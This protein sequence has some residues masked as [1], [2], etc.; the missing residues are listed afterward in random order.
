MPTAQEQQV[1][2]DLRRGLQSLY[3][4]RLARL[5]LFGSRARG[6]AEP[7]SDYDVL[8]VLRGVVDPNEESR[9]TS[10]FLGDI[11]SA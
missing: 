3:G 11:Q 5:I 9:R 1:L 2:L 6:D 8:V 10:E 4:D 7:E